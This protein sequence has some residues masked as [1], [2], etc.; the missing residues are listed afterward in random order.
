[1]KATPFG[2]SMC[3]FMPSY[4]YASALETSNQSIASFLQPHHYAE[5]STAIVDA[6]I[7]GK[8]LRPDTNNPSTFTEISTPNFTHSFYLS[9][10]ALKLQVAPQWSF[11]LIY[12]QPFG[13]D[14]GYTLEP[15]VTSP[16]DLVNAVHFKLDTH[17]L[18][19]LV[20]YQP[21]PFWNFY[22]GLS[23]Q[24]LETQLKISGQSMGILADYVADTNQ[25]P[26]MGWLT[27]ISYQIPEYAL[28]TSLTYRSKI[29]HKPQF[30]EQTSSIPEIPALNLSSTQHISIATPQSL[31]LEFQSGISPRNLV[32]T[33]L[34][35]V[36]WKNF[37]MISPLMSST[38]S[39][40]V[41]LVDYQKN[42]LSTTLGFAHILNEQ[43]TT[44][45]DIGLDSGIGNPASTL[46]PSDDYYSLGIGG[47]YHMHSN[48]F[49]AAG[50][51]YFKLNKAKVEQNQQGSGNLFG[52]LSSVNHN[53]AIAYGLKL[54]YRF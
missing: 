20:G 44:A 8:T 29:R 37:K 35:W 49:I 12:D 5:F 25:D 39:G 30:H 33:S 18:T 50:I 9:N 17:N 15:V 40:P 14:I 19:A 32:Y 2:I 38:E 42:Q 52:V 11:G 24:T 43:W 7:S 21:S 26:A 28:K 31:N 53:K 47:V 36:N 41:N 22:T 13:T 4:L 45:V 1:M 46:S 54:G 23:Y 27:G 3:M 48:L 16:A 10:V 6:N 34:R 51:K